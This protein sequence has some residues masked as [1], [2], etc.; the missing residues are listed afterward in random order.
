[1]SPTLDLAYDCS[2]FVST[3]FE[4]INLSSPHIYHSALALA[5]KTSIVRNLYQLRARPLVRIVY[6]LPV[7]W[8]SSIVATTCPF[9]IGLAAWSPCNRFIA[10]S[11][12][13]SLKVDVLDS[14]T[15]QKL[16]SFKFSEDQRSFRKLIFSPDSRILTCSHTK[17]AE[18]LVVSWDLLTGGVAGTIQHRFPTGKPHKD[19][20]TYSTNGKEIAILHLSGLEQVTLSIYDAARHKHMHD[21]HIASGVTPCGIW[22]HRGSLRLAVSRITPG[23]TGPMSITIWEVGFTPGATKTAVETLSIPS[24]P[25]QFRSLESIIY[26]PLPS[27]PIP[28]TL[29]S[30]DDVLVWDARNSQSLLHFQDPN[31]SCNMNFS[32]DGRFVAGSTS[33]SGVRIWKYS[34]AGYLLHGMLPS[35]PA[36]NTIPLLSSDGES[37]IVFV[38]G[39]SAFNLWHA[40]NFTIP[41]SDSSFGYTSRFLL[42][43][44]PNRLLAAV[45]RF[46]GSRV[47]L[48]DISSGALQLTID[49]GMRVEGL[50]VTEDAVVV[51]GEGKATTWRLPWGTLLPGT[52]MNIADSTRTIFLS[53]SRQIGPGVTALISPDLRYIIVEANR[54]EYQIHSATTGKPFGNF[55]SKRKLIWF[56]PD[57][58]HIGNLLD[59]GKADIWRITTEGT[60]ELSTRGIDVDEGL[61]G[62]PY[63]PSRGYRIARDG[64]VFGPSGMRLLILPP[65]WRSNTTVEGWKWSGKIFGLLQGVLPEPVVIDTGP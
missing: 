63:I 21:V 52:T 12:R 9:K 38:F 7:S 13:T 19:Y 62:C 20:I 57:G 60:L 48:F 53:G 22:T 55:S 32:S 5:P 56:T 4:I 3:N 43:I 29:I 18:W 6:G 24:G 45:M 34:P 33:G 49:A 17:G 14:V 51:I 11:P 40:K 59:G 28:V 31:P 41:F 2:R 39:D 47:T 23:G 50:G 1:M 25:C 26:P 44:F 61:W 37:V 27:A 36:D 65:L 8:D 35:D 15:L 10:I 54:F 42:E 46:L 16:Q 58:H 64:W 30:H